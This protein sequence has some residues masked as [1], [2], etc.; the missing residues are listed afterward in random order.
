MN[1]PAPT[2]GTGAIPEIEDG[3]FVG[4]FNDIVVRVVEAFK[5]EKDT[6]GHPDDGT[7]YDFNT[8]VLDADRNPVMLVD[9]KE[10]AEDPTEEFTLR[11]AK[12]VRAIT[13]GERSNCYAYL[14]GIL[15]PV[16][17]QLFIAAG[18]GDE[19]ADAMWAAAAEKVNGRDVNIQVSH[20]EKGWPQIEAFLG[21]AKPLKAAK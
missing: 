11:Q 7:R 18:K 6:Y 10:G 8:T 19:Q 9:V 5:T 14:K 4:R 17:M 1:I 3:L 15:T 13:A 21:A 20:N 2:Q 12:S 16:E